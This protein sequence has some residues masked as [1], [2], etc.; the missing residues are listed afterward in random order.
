ME[1]IRVIDA[2]KMV[3]EF[4]GHK[5]ESS[6]CQYADG[7]AESRG[8]QFAGEKTNGWEPKVPFREGPEAHIDWYFKDGIARTWSLSSSGCLRSR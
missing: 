3:M 8:G 7:S 5:A 2:A 6:C 4:T 1:R